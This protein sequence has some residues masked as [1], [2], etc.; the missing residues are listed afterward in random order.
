MRR[1]VESKTDEFQQSF[2]DLERRFNGELIRNVAV[3]SIGV[4]EAVDFISAY[5]ILHM[6]ENNPHFTFRNSDHVRKT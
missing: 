6:P 2:K 5:I 3:V 1:D 4:Y